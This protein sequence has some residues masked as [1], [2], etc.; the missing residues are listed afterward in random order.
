MQKLMINATVMADD[1]LDLGLVHRLLAVLGDAGSVSV[2]AVHYRPREER[3]ATVWVFRDSDEGEPYV[4]VDEAYDFE[5]DP[6][7]QEQV[8]MLMQEGVCTGMRA[9]YPRA[10]RY[11]TPRWATDLQSG[12]AEM[13]PSMEGFFI[14]QDEFEA[15]AVDTGDDSSESFWFQIA[16]PETCALLRSIADEKAADD[17]AGREA[18]RASLEDREPEPEEG[19]DEEVDARMQQL[20]DRVRRNMTE[21]EMTAALEGA[22]FAVSETGHELVVA[23]AAAIELGDV[24]ESV[25]DN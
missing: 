12:T 8:S 6:L 13:V 5:G 25:L 9:F 14:A 15:Q 7:S 10:D 1:N 22:G 11:G 16:L 21:E 24:S 18:L 3:N 23:L 17:A 4:L 19:D 2:T 20:C